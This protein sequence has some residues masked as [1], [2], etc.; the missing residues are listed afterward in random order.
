MSRASRPRTSSCA[1]TPARSRTTSSSKFSR[2]NQG[3]CI[4]QRPIVGAGERVAKG[5]VIADGPS[6]SHGE[7]SL[8]KN[9]LVGFMNWEGYNYEDAILLNEQPR[10]GGRVHLHPH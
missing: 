1:T 2:S 5:D 6:T 7:I 9:I 8:G 4:N 3:T 10:H